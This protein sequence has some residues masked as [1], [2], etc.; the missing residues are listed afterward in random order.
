[1]DDDDEFGDLYTDVLRPLTAAAAADPTPRTLHDGG[2]GGGAISYRPPDRHLGPPP[3]QTLAPPPPKIHDHSQQQHHHHHHHHRVS[4]A[5]VAANSNHHTPSIDRVGAPSGPSGVLDG[6]GS[7]LRGEGLESEKGDTFGR[8]EV[9][10]D[11]EAGAM[12]PGLSSGGGGGSS[13][14]FIPGIFE[15]ESAAKGLVSENDEP[16]GGGGGGGEDWDSDSDDD[17]QIVLNEETG[18]P[19]M[20]DEGDEDGEDLV[21]VADG[22]QVHQPVEE[23]EWGDEAAQGADVER[24]DPGELGKAS[25]AALGVGAARIGYSS[26]GYHPYHSQFKYIRPGAAVAPGGMP[27]GPAGSTVQM[28]PPLSIGPMVGR[29]RGDWRPIGMK[30]APTMQKGFHPGYGPAWGANS[31]GRGFGGG[32]EFTLPSH[33]TVFEIDIDSFEEKPW[34][35]PGEQLR[36]EATM[37]SKI[38]VYESGRSEQ[39]YDPDMPPELAAATG[40]H[41]ASAENAQLGRTYATQNDPLGQGRGA[42]RPTGRAIQVESGYGERL[43]SIDTRPPRVRDSDAIIEIVL[44]GSLD[45]PMEADDAPEQPADEDV[46]GAGA[47]G[48][49]EEDNEQNDSESF[50]RIPQNYSGRKRE[51]MRRESVTDSINDNNH[52]GGGI[53]LAPPDG[54]LKNPSGSR[55]RSRAYSSGSFGSP[56]NGR[57]PL[58]KAE[59]GSEASPTTSSQA[60]GV[61]DSQSEKSGESIGRK[62]SP[63]SSSPAASERARKASVE[64]K[65]DL[66]DEL[67]LDENSVGIERNEMVMNVDTPGESLQDGSSSHS[68][69]KQKLS[70]RVEQPI[71]QDIG[72]GDELRGTR[73]SDNSKVR[74]GSSKDYNKQRDGGEEEVVQ[75]GHSIRLVDMKR[76]RDEDERALRRKDDYGKDGRHE[77]DRNHMIVKGREESH[78]SYHYR[79]WDPSAAYGSRTK[80]GD[81]E[82]R[83]DSVGSRRRDDDLH[84]RRVK[85]EDIR[86]RE[87]VEEMGYRS[88]TK[89]REGERA[90]KEDY[91]HSRKWL[92]NGDWRHEKDVSSR[93]R[94]RD[95]NSSNW[96]DK[97]DDSTSK[98]RKD[99]E[100]LRREQ[101]EREISHGYGAREDSGR[102]KRERDDGL[103]HR[104]REDQHRARDKLDDSHSVRNKDDNWRPRER[105]DRQRLKQPNEDMLSARDR[106][107]RSAVRSG[108]AVED[109]SWA[110]NARIK[111]DSRSLVSEDYQFKDKRRHG[112]REP[113]KRI[114]RKEDDSLSQHRGRD[115]LYGRESQFLLD[116]RN[117]RH[118][119]SSAHNDHGINAS[120]NNKLSHKERHTESRK[121]KDSEGVD[122]NIV[123]ASKRKREDYSATRGEKVG[124]KAVSEQPK[125]ASSNSR[126]L[127]QSRL[128]SSMVSSRK[129]HHEH[130]IQEHHSSRKH[131][132]DAPSDDEQHDSR[133]GRSKLERWTSHK[134]RDLDT[135]SRS[136]SSKDK[137]VGR[138][139]NDLSPLDGGKVDD[140][141]LMAEA[142]NDQHPLR[143]DKSSHNL[144]LNEANSE[145]SAGGKHIESDKALD[146]RHLDT[147][148]KL[149][150]RSERFKTPLPSEKDGSSNR[151]SDGEALVSAQTEA[152]AD[153]DIKTE[154]PARKRSSFEWIALFYDP[155]RA[156][157][158]FP[159]VAFL[160]GASPLV[161]LS[162]V[163]FQHA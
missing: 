103:D 9:G 50:D 97:F 80:N 4:G 134:D 158:H 31:M 68:S 47:R 67:A 71:L 44:Q 18:R 112:E 109:K 38:R 6:L 96:Q 12:I 16:A 14:S 2:G 65:G 89:V 10:D 161:H 34:K 76:H 159:V 60:K 27:P 41:E 101:V 118:E 142:A 86:N 111:D 154:R 45:D 152:A 48:D 117:L 39:D 108:R 92:D 150:K 59:H 1:M 85:D 40:I 153:A 57:Y 90:E 130:D 116:D 73:S 102:R 125:L 131:R 107:G 163:L 148:A 104:R 22:D 138:N 88:R 162:N 99:E 81:F 7:E 63:E 115:D 75:E 151:K 25:S 56:Q 135:N 93:Q 124:S 52:E 43:P 26:H 19:G 49:V 149:K 84:G 126:D 35:H 123:G 133:R 98:R 119:R 100:Y 8:L 82:R 132:D 77:M 160:F 128:S 143:E 122:H 58:Q 30:T 94:E 105:E 70:S 28:R 21:I 145:P 61:R 66:Q 156:I 78:H 72:S 140:S 74:S 37:Q 129:S 20:P 5:A 110:G 91:L 157:S 113:P 33:K 51:T 17:L 95:E 55:G 106:E 29:G 62:E 121:G 79:D 64:Y 155:L 144:N 11:V 42:T 3:H 15:D 54:M 83:D 36:L 127:S 87:R 53:L 114:D 23:Q 136:I 141:S 32:L 24:K 46:Q 69:K 137:D 147:V 146:D 120:D 13:A 139:D